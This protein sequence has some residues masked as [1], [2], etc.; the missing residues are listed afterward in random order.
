M[1][2]AKVSCSAGAADVESVVEEPEARVVDLGKRETAPALIASTMRCGSGAGQR[3]ET[4]PG[5][6]GFGHDSVRHRKC[7][8]CSCPAA[9]ISLM[10][11]FCARPSGVGR[12]LSGPGSVP[13]GRRGAAVD[14]NQAPRHVEAAVGPA[15]VHAGHRRCQPPPTAARQCVASSSENP[16][17]AC[18]RLRASESAVGRPSDPSPVFVPVLMRE[19]GISPR[20]VSEGGA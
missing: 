10:L 5:R 18:H 6:Q 1:S 8:R 9:S 2:R 16:P 3:C 19:L 20:G 4:I 15:V 17:S 13:C 7:V 11:A 12:W 14:G